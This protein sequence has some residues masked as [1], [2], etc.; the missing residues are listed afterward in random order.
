MYKIKSLRSWPDSNPGLQVTRPTPYPQR[1]KL[2]CL[3]LDVLRTHSN[4][5]WY[6]QLTW[7]WWYHIVLLNTWIIVYDSITIVQS[8]PLFHSFHNIEFFKMVTSDLN[9]ISFSICKELEKL[10]K[11][12]FFPKIFTKT[13]YSII[14]GEIC[15]K[16]YCP[17]VS[18]SLITFWAT[19]KKLK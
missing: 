7:L 18:N 11:M 3:R 6:E 2:I 12:P 17:R 15:K 4:W 13:H 10:R 19:V 1:H 5:C 14:F 16:T 9:S 8:E